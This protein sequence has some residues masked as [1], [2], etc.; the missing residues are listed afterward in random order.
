MADLLPSSPNVSG[1]DG[2]EP[3]V[4]GLDSDAADDLLSALSSRTARRLLAELH[5]EPATPSALADRVDTSLQN[6]QY[7][8]GKLEDAE[9]IE[10][11]DVAYSA[12]GREMRVY[13][14]ADR[15][16]V[17]VAGREEDT[18]GLK[19]TLSRLL[20]G[21][22][23]LGLASLL[24]DR[25]L[26]TPSPDGGVATTLSSDGGGADAGG[27]SGG[28]GSGT[29]ASF[30]A[31]STSDSGNATAAGGASATPGEAVTTSA[32]SATATPVPTP[33]ATSTPSYETAMST[34]APDAALIA[35]D[36]T[37]PFELVAGSPGLLFFLG[38]L[39]AL[40]LVA[41]LLWR[42]S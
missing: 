35:A 32:E 40:L 28:S 15:A 16:L 13:A 29:D 37:T 41:L 24:V 22:G 19:A 10:V 42:D 2:A 36:P 30:H 4:I 12:K 9:L 1:V 7:H 20:G 8:L 39:T 23:V 27:G 17:V 25:L 21:V 5:E 31:Q 11:A 14:P 26:R 3:R 18:T 33:A 6:A 34:P 38:G